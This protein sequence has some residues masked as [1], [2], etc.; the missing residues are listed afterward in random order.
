INMNLLE[1][2]EEKSVYYLDTNSILKNEDGNMSA[3]FTNSSDGIHINKEAYDIWFN[4]LRNHVV[5]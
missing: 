1:L 2:C 4:Y 5:K 3:E